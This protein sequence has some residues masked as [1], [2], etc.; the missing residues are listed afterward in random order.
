M[1]FLTEISGREPQII[2]LFT[3]AFAA[4]EG[5]DE[6]AVIGT[7]VRNLMAETSPDD[8]QPFMAYTG[9]ALI[10]GIFFSRLRFAEGDR[11]VVMLS[12]VAVATDQ[13]GQ[14]VGQ[15]LIRHG[16]SE[17]SKVGV[18][19]AV[20]YGDPDYYGRVGF[21][22]VSEEIVPPPLPLQYPH[23]WLAQAL[24]GNDLIPLKGPSECVQAFNDPGYW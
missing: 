12:P 14:G 3:S 7:L 24:S 9:D 5:A 23:G 13:Q 16:L 4:S 15:A 17:M 2:D 6:G 18:E 20:T 11:K 22:T 19:V 1:D 8:L 21:V 10:G